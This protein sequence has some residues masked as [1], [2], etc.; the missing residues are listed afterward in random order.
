MENLL[1]M[2]E[3]CGDYIPRA[4]EKEYQSFKEDVPKK[5]GAYLLMSALNMNSD[6]KLCVEVDKLN[7]SLKYLS[8]SITIP[9]SPA[10]LMH[11]NQTCFSDLCEQWKLS[12]VVDF[13]SNQSDEELVSEISKFLQDP[14]RMKQ[15]YPNL[16]SW[17]D[18]EIKHIFDQSLLCRK[19]LSDASLDIS[20]PRTKSMPKNK[21][22]KKGS[23]VLKT[24]VSEPEIDY[25]K[26]FKKV[27]LP[28]KK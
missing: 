28:V 27:T 15:L 16:C 2:L 5:L 8:Q 19:T 21:P 10:A 4:V 9:D 18:S 1:E 23:F 26:F 12:E 14:L 7:D 13:S 24:S 17:F 3:Y 25:S 11:L 22:R 20:V 6:K